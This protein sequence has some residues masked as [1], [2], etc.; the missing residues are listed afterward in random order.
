MRKNSYLFLA[1]CSVFALCLSSVK[2]LASD[3]AEEESISKPIGVSEIVLEDHISL[4][5]SEDEVEK[6][7]LSESR[8]LIPLA[9]SLP[10]PILLDSSVDSNGRR[11]LTLDGGGQRGI[12]QTYFMALMEERTG[13]PI[14]KLF[15]LIAGTSAG[16]MGALM[17]VCPHPEDSSRAKYSMSQALDIMKGSKGQS[18]FRKVETSGWRT[19]FSGKFWHSVGRTA[20]ALG[21]L[22]MPKY[23]RS[24]LEYFLEEQFGDTRLSEA[25]TNVMISAYQLPG[26]SNGEGKP[27][28][29]KS[30]KSKK[31]S[32]FDRL[33]CQVAGATS[34]APTFFD[35]AKVS[36]LDEE[37]IPTVEF[38][39]YIDGGVFANNPSVPGAAEL[40][41]E[42]LDAVEENPTK[43]MNIED[44]RFSIVSLGTGRK[45][46]EG[47]SSHQYYGKGTLF[48]IKEL[49]QNIMIDGVSSTNHYILERLF[50]HDPRV[51][52]YV[53]WNPILESASTAMDDSSSENIK[54]LLDDARDYTKGNFSLSGD[55]GSKS[56]YDV[57][58]KALGFVEEDSVSK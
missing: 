14:W 6:V 34:A 49:L 2:T 58:S 50:K 45:I 10:E 25:L 18:I 52:S 8:A 12:M 57:L 46:N 47:V 43:S 4:D 1:S 13:Q 37:G 11:I 22:T 24:N 55:E 44:A 9:R 16:G 17:A 56:H 40:L 51:D 30:S 36:R 20:I 31:N 54:N 26:P 19:P 35:P 48:W 21:G 53:R 23:S 29:F 39:T 27:Y 32:R 33:M 41:I 7:V 38:E 5:L 28:F 15:D 42:Y 3:I